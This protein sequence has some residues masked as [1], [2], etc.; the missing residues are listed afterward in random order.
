MKLTKLT[1]ILALLAGLGLAAC[2]QDID[3]DLPPYESKLVLECYLEDGQPVRLS[4][5]E[6]RSYLDISS[7]PLVDG[8]T[9]VLSHRGQNDTIPNVPAID[10]TSG[11]SYNYS[12]PKRI[13]ANYDS[14][15]TLTVKDKL[16]RVLTATTRF[17]KPVAIKSITPE[18]NQKGEAYGLTKFD[19]NAQ[20]KNYYRLTL[21]R[22]IRVDT[23]SLDALLDDAFSN[24][25]EINWGSGYTFKK[26]DTIHA[27]LYHCTEDYYKFLTTSQSARQANVN[28][29][30]ASGEV[31]SN[32]KGGLGVFATLAY[33]YRSVVVK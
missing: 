5:L 3:V 19:D 8:A 31:I 22:N 11:K 14:P 7:L 2:Q 33:D 13:K 26:G 4:L 20:Q 6:S 16:G 18:F 30:A 21:T 10:R 25:E 29:F 23:L 32:I 9:V 24:G 28:P 12:S 27:T 15:Y 17:I 1:Y